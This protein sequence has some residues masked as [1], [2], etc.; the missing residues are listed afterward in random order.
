MEETYPVVEDLYAIEYIEVYYDEKWQES[1]YKTLKQLQKS[2]KEKGFELE[3][4][5]IAF[6][7]YHTD[8]YYYIDRFGH[9]HIYRVNS[10]LRRLREINIHKNAGHFKKDEED[11][12]KQT[13]ET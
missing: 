5:A 11:G 6:D 1:A 13:K 10:I 3:Q 12:Q 4:M 8:R 9:W 2:I 7:D